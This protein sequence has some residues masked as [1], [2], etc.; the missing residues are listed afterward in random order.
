MLIFMPAGE[1]AVEAAHIFPFTKSFDDSIGNGLSLCP[2]RHWSFDKG[3]FSID[4][5][6]KMIV[7]DNFEEIGT[8][9]AGFYPANPEHSIFI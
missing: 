2:L 9:D 6:Y 4:D 8:A 7:S 1:T 5:D 3:L